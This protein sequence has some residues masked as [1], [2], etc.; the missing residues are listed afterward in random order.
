MSVLGGGLDTSSESLNLPEA[1]ADPPAPPS[2]HG[3]ACVWPLVTMTYTSNTKYMAISPL[4]LLNGHPIRT[5]TTLTGILVASR[6]P[7]A[8]EPRPHLLT[9]PLQPPLATT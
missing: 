6:A 3:H 2:P 7:F 9:S 5:T 8:V 4:N 1:K